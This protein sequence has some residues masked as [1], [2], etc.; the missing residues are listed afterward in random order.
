MSKESK[1]LNCQCHALS[2]SLKN[3]CEMTFG[4]QG[5]G[6]CNVFQAVFVYVKMIKIL[7]EDGGAEILDTV[8]IL[9]VEN[10]VDNGNWQ[11]YARMYI[12]HT[13]TIVKSAGILVYLIGGCSKLA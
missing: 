13:S 1:K 6:Q 12:K 5:I 11:A 2:I 4:K 3:S 8:H 9:V 10:L 7:C